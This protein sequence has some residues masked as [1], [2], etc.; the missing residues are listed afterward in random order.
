MGS[1]ARVYHGVPLPSPML[2]EVRPAADWPL[3]FLSSPPTSDPPFGKKS[4][5]QTLTVE[6]CGTAGEPGLPSGELAQCLATSP[7]H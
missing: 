2:G 1:R 3:S 6:L 5:E 4:F 7:P